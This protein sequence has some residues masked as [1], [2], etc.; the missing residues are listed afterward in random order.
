MAAGLSPEDESDPLEGGADVMAREVGGNLVI[1]IRPHFHEF[2]A[3]LWPYQPA[4]AAISPP[5]PPDAPAR[6]TFPPAG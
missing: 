1:V 3:R 5:T 4:S 6:K 2:L